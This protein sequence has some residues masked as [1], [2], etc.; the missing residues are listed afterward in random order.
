MKKKERVILKIH[1][2][3]KSSKNEIVGYYHD[4]LRIKVTAPPVDGQANRACIR[5]LAGFFELKR[6]Q[7][8]IVKGYTSRV[9]LLE[10]KGI[11]KERL[12]KRLKN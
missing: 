12:L 4:T 6:S 5:Y 3:P 8:S 11:G 10:I 2:Q 1:V 9:K 7:L